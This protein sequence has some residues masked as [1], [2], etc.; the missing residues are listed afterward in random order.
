[1][2]NPELERLERLG[3]AERIRHWGTDRPWGGLRLPKIDR[4][5]FTSR[6]RMD[7]RGNIIAMPM[8]IGRPCFGQPTGFMR[9]GGGGRQWNPRTRSWV[10]DRC[11]RCAVQSA[12][13]FV[14]GERLRATPQ[15]D[16][17]Y[18]E[19]A[20][21]GGRESTWPTK[22]CPGTALVIYRDLVRLLERQ[23]EFKSI[24]DASVVA[25]YD[26]LGAKHRAQDAA[27][28]RRERVN[29]VLE[30]ARRGEFGQDVNGA[31]EGQ[32]VWR[33][34][35]HRRAQEHPQGP[36]RIRRASAAALFDARA[37]LAKTRLE[38]RG[39]VANDSNVALE[40]QAIGFEQQ[41]THN[42]LRDA[43][44]RAMSRID[45]LERTRLPGE[46]EAIWPRFGA[47]ELREQLAWNSLQGFD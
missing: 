44:R 26:E 21:L 22:G 11:G 13:S 15:I 28:K 32:T 8:L 37:W 43:V 38:V 17:K 3:H 46:S 47:R 24:N 35:Q 34:V 39:V 7:D 40:M 19:W 30:H 27:R 5:F 14:A 10:P 18:R 33:S 31:L 41:R 42:A 45:L 20:Y 12:C 29:A 36:S 1:M 23:V 6:V 2:P 16:A 9:H 4:P 25:H